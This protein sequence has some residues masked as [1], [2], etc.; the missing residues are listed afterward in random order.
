MLLRPLGVVEAR[1][2]GGGV[3]LASLE[4]LDGGGDEA[5]TRDIL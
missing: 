1:G 2:E 4:R 3:A 5:H